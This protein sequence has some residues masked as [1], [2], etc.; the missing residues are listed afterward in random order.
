MELINKPEEKPTE[1][2]HS[3][4]SFCSK[5]SPV[6]PRFSTNHYKA[7]EIPEV[8]EFIF[9]ELI[10]TICESPFVNDTEFDRAIAE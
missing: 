2:C 8:K 10:E 3:E 6:I 9:D 1:C 4:L 7:M 5:C